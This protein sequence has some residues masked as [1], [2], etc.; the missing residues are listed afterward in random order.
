[1]IG[2]QTLTNLRVN[3][4]FSLCLN[5]KGFLLVDSYAIKTSDAKVHVAKLAL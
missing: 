4:P 3:N 5:N 1:M 2:F